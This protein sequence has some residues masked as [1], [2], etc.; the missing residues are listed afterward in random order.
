MSLRM[1]GRLPYLLMRHGRRQDEE[2]V[3]GDTAQ[4]GA[5]TLPVK[6][7]NLAD[8]MAHT[9]GGEHRFDPANHIVW[10]ASLVHA[11]AGSARTRRGSA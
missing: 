5:A 7:G 10:P 3:I 2:F 8:D 9:A 6:Q 1:K 4:A 11:A